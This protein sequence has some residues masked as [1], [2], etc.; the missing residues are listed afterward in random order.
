MLTILFGLPCAGKNYVG[1]IFEKHFSYYFYDADDDLTPEI[2]KEIKKGIMISDEM[3]GRYYN[4]ILGKVKILTKK[5]SNLVMSQAFIK[6][7]YRHLFL[8]H[9]PDSKFILIHAE[10]GIKEQRSK[11]RKHIVDTKYMKKIKKCFETPEIK[12]YLIENNKGEKEIIKQINKI[13]N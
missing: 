13:I 1:E 7:K 6:R 11:N 12:H 4:D 5:Y 2:K 3:R 9:F 8:D 10:Q